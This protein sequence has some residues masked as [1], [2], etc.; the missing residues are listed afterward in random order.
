MILD[1]S[2]EGIEFLLNDAW[3]ALSENGITRKMY[4]IGYFKLMKELENSPAICKA[5]GID[6]NDK[7]AVQSLKDNFKVHEDDMLVT[8]VKEKVDL[9]AIGVEVSAE[10]MKEIEDRIKAEEI[11][12]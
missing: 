12:P 8:V 3:R 1:K 4:S 9:K 5:F 6:I 2:K 10:K 7:K 11:K